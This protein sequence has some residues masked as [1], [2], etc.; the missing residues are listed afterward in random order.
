MT[1][2]AAPFTFSTGR[3]NGLVGT[4]SRP[5]TAGTLEIESADDFILGSTTSITHAAFYG[6]LPAGLSLS[7]INQVRVEIY[8]V[9]PNDSVNPPSGHVPT[10]ANSPSDVAFEE[11]DS[12]TSTLSF[13]TAIVDP[14]FTVANSVL[15][16]IFPS[17]NQTTHGEGPVTGEEVL[18]DVVLSTP[19]FL[20]ADHYFFIPQVGLNSGNFLWLSAPKPTVPPFTGDL[21]SWIRN[22]NL[23]P[24]WLRVGTDVIGSGT[25]NAAFSIS[26]DAV[27]EPGTTAL[28]AGGLLLIGLYRRT[29]KSRKGI[30]SRLE[31]RGQ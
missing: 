26:G 5:G 30:R 31:E 6:L 19:L 21:Q 23:A 17:P 13:T 11:R 10:R 14:S 8:R 1:A 7:D 22:E 24:D 3:P 16:G 15:N 28:L 9:F 18:F 12:A 29:S 20:P 27:P 2:G 4:G 25:F